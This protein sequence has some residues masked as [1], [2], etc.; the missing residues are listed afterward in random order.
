MFDTR[1]SLKTSVRI[2]LILLV[3]AILMTASVAIAKPG[4]NKAPGKP[5]ATA[6]TAAYTGSVYVRAAFGGPL[7]GA[8]VV[9]KGVESNVRMS[10]YTDASGYVYFDGLP[11]GSYKVSAAFTG[12]S[13]AIE[14]LGVPSSQAEVITL[15]LKP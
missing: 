12:Y 3:V 15:H 1:N 4:K 7:A 11:A 9:L 8:K 13:S 14:T 10:G 2:A 5:V 6:T